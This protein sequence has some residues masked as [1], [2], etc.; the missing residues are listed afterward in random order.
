VVVGPVTW[1]IE[2][3]AME[4]LQAGVLHQADSP[5]ALVEHVF[6]LLGDGAAAEATRQAAMDFCSAHRGAAA[7]HRSCLL[8]WMH[9]T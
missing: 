2:F 6:T 3:P 8:Q 9:A 4:A 5:Q 7:R 1:T